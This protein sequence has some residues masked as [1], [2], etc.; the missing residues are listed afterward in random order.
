VKP[1][2]LAPEA[3]I[4]RCEDSDFRRPAAPENLPTLP[5]QQRGMEALAFGLSFSEKRFNTTVT[6][7]PG[8]GKTTTVKRIVEERAAAEPP[9]SDICLHQNFSNPLKPKVLYL[10]AGGGRQVNRMVEDLLTL[11]GKHI[12]KMLEQPDTKARIQEIQ[13][14][15]GQQERALSHE[16][17]AFAEQIGVAVQPTPQGMNLIPLKEGRPMQEEE[18]FSLS[19]EDRQAIDDRRKSLLQRMAEVNPRLLALEKQRRQDVEGFVEQLV[20]EM[21]RGYLS[22]MRKRIQDGDRLGE[23]LERLGEEIVEKRFLFLSDALG[24][25]PFG[26]AQLEVM[27]QQFAQSC[28]LNVLVDRSGQSSAPVLMELNPNYSNLIGGID[29]VEEHGVLKTDF[30]QIRAGSLIQADGGYLILQAADLI[31]QPMAY[32]A[33]KRALR[34]GRVRL[35]DPLTELGMRTVSHLEAEPVDIRVSV[36]LIGSEEL[37]DLI[38]IVDDEFT[39]LFKIRAD[40]SG[41][42]VR[43]PEV[44]EQYAAYLDYQARENGVLP[45]AQ[46]AL[47]RLIEESSRMV[48]HQRRLSGQVTELVDI[49]VEANQ[50]ARAEGA[51]E[52]TRELVHRALE[53]RHYRHSKFEEIV[54][55]EISEGT[56]LVDFD[57]LRAGQVNGLAV[58]QAGRVM[59]GVPTRI[60]AQ[61]YAGRTGI[62]NVERE[63]DLSGRIHTKGVLIL[64]GYL[65]RLFARKRPLALSVSITFEQNY[66]G[67]EGDSATCAEFFVTV[68][69]ISGV[70]LKQA[71]AV[72]GSMNQHGQV[73]PIGGVNEKIVGFFRFAKEHGF[74]EGSGV[75]IPAQN[76]INLM[77]PPDVIEAAEAGKFHIYPIERVEDGLELMTGLPAGEPG[78]DGE[79][80][81]GSV[82]G[83]AMA[84]LKEF[85]RH[86]EAEHAP[87]GA[88]R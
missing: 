60:T 10:A 65:G 57:G 37:I 56:I 17:D 85:S 63:A 48:S 46:G 20:R 19:V 6:G 32:Q 87:P 31:Q 40:F 28:K 25:T 33:L 76:A 34:S 7:A 35:Q 75:I 66:G 70:P 61:A 16:I 68:S 38:R 88:E 83:M 73:Q 9:A 14:R 52:L 54:Q 44:M 3:L 43:T 4:C 81:P 21:V 50:F 23:Y 72:T 67:I 39:R 15:F 36:V 74:P 77:L 1:K 69:A 11:L 5:G 24:T 58:Y 22:E 62:I 41:T 47:A 64:N 12:P 59:F 29:Y 49:L 13:D 71:I 45:L 26:T 78:P 18:F 27:R 80:P 86:R 55:R 42:I 53:Y 30:S 82:F 51:N 84:Q 8:S 2:P 79:Y